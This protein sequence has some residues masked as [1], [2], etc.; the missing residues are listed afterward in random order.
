LTQ[1][2]ILAF[3]FKMTRKPNILFL[4]NDHQT[5]YGHGKMAGGPEI[6]RPN[7]ERLA[8]EGIEFTNAYTACPLCGPARRTFL[9]GLYPH[10]HYELLNEV[11]YPF[12]NETYLQVLAKGGYNNYYYGKWHAGPG[13]AH[14]HHCEGLCLPKFGNPLTTPEYKQYLKQK[15]LPHFRAKLTH[16]FYNPEW[17]RSKETNIQIGES[18]SPPGKDYNEGVFGIMETPVETHESYFL[19]NLAI[20]TLNKI[21]ES[22]NSQPFHMRVDFWSPHPPYF[23]SQ[24]FLDLY[25]PE[26]IAEHP[27]FDASLSNNK[28]EIYRYDVYHPISNKGRLVYPNPL[29]WSE[30]QKVLAMTYAHITLVD[31]AGGL[32][33]DALDKLGLSG[34]TIVI[35]SLDHGDALACHGGHFDKD[36]YMPQ[37]LL[38]IPLVVRYP[39]K[40]KPNYK[41][42]KLVSTIDFAPTILDAAGLSFNKSV[43]GRSFFPI[44]LGKDI[45]WRED[46]MCETHGHFHIH[47]GRALIKDQYKYIYN[48]RE[49]DELYDLKN[50]PY[51][52]NN[53]IHQK[54]YAHVVENMKLRLK[55]WRDKTNDTMKKRAIH[56]I[57]SQNSK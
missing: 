51:E 48:E 20:D 35:W 56:K 4:F 40:I 39:D 18:Y 46:L 23:V 12:K 19:A 11:N 30:W 22:D 42:N 9:T 2:N 6:Q 57:V 1:D 13:T 47:L 43:D 10:N 50:D 36:C 25:N 26:D 15:N 33:L 34:N 21:A 55:N 17:E 44:C 27:N 5:Y 52:L 3:R 38:R 37:E 31:Y 14:D 32:I 29:P 28:P 8:R 41:S 7:F 45:K 16:S 24:D 54:D 53:L 49:L